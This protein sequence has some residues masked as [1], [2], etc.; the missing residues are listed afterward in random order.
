MEL[1]ITFQH[2]PLDAEFT[3]ED[4]E[5]IQE[6]LLKFVDFL[7]EN[8]EQFQGIEP[9]KPDSEELEEP[10]L[11]SDRWQDDDEEESSSDSSSGSDSQDNPLSSLARKTDNPVE[12]LEDLIYVDPDN[13]EDPQLMLD[14]DR[15]G[16]NRAER[17][18]N[19]AY[20][21]LRVWEECYDEERMKTSKLKNIFTMSGISDNSLYNAWGGSGKGKFDATGKGSS[22]TVGLTGPGKR[23][24][25][26]VIQELPETT[27]D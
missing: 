12:E 5:E 19:A 25:L 3:G 17:Q 16:E 18:R 4:R 2:G 24:A 27:S 9:P 10:S 13:E 6:D 8:A 7:N 26:K 11:D 22:A 15:L 20:I 23:K 1:T 21:I 14:K